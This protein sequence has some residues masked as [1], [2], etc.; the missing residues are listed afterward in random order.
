MS[1]KKARLVTVNNFKYLPSNNLY[2][3]KQT[4]KNTKLSNYYVINTKTIGYANRNNKSFLYSVIYKQS[5]LL[6]SKIGKKVISESY[7]LYMKPFL[8]KNSDL[9]YVNNYDIHN[10]NKGYSKFFDISSTT[11]NFKLSM[12]RVKQYLYKRQSWYFNTIYKH[13][14]R[15]RYEKEDENKL[16]YRKHTKYLF[17]KV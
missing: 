1:S 13:K 10:L 4:I 15:H 2:N 16:L 17:N 12:V 8:T 5:N 3:N 11:T 6:A 7:P 9:N 14:I